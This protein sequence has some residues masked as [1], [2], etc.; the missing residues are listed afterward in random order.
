MAGMRALLLTAALGLVAGQVG[1]QCTNPTAPCDFTL[2]PTQLINSTDSETGYYFKFTVPANAQENYDIL[3]TQLY[4]NVQVYVTTNGALPS[5]DNFQA[6]TATSAIPTIVTLR[7]GDYFSTDGDTTVNMYVQAK[8]PSLAYIAASPD[9]GRI[10]LIMGVP[11]VD[12]AGAETI[13]VYEVT[14]P[15]GEDHGDIMFAVSFLA[16]DDPN[17]IV[18]DGTTTKSSHDEGNDHVSFH[19]GV[20]DHDVTYTIEVELSESE[21][22]FFLVHATSASKEYPLVIVPGYYIEDEVPLG[23]MRF[24]ALYVPPTHEELT[25]RVEP[26]HGNPQLFAEADDWFEWSMGDPFAQATWS[27][28]NF[29]GADEIDINPEDEHYIAEGGFYKVTIIGGVGWSDDEGTNTEYQIGAMTFGTAL[30]LKDGESMYDRIAEGHY[31][32]F[33]YYDTDPDKDLVIDVTAINGDPDIFVACTLDPTGDDSGTPSNAEGHFNVSSVSPGDD[34]LTIPSGS[35]CSRPGDPNMFYIGVYA[36]S[37]SLIRIATSHADPA[38]SVLLTAGQPQAGTVEAGELHTY[39]LEAKSPPQQIEITL[40]PLEGDPDLYVRM[41][42][43]MATVAEAM[44]EADYTA[45]AFDFAVDKVVIPQDEVCKNCNIYVAVHGFTEASYILAYSVNKS[46]LALVE[47]TPVRSSVGN[48]EVT[49]FSYL[50]LGPGDVHFTLTMLSGSA[51]LVATD[52]RTVSPRYPAESNATRVDDSALIGRVPSIVYSGYPE[53][54]MYT[55]GVQGASDSTFTLVA[56]TASGGDVVNTLLLGSPQDAVSSDWTTLYYVVT[57]PSGH[58]QLTISSR[59]RTGY[60]SVF[61]KSCDVE[62]MTCSKRGNYSFGLPGF[63]DN[64]FS[65]YS[66]DALIRIPYSNATS[67]NYFIAVKTDA[68]TDVTTQAT[69]E[70][71]QISLQIGEPYREYLEQDQTS[72]YRFEV[73]ADV[74]SDYILISVTDLSG[75]DPDVY[76]STAPIQFPNSTNFN[77]ANSRYGSESIVIHTNRNDSNA[78]V[79]CAYFVGVFAF[80]ETEYSIT[81]T[82]YQDTITTLQ[83]GQPQ[84]GHVARGQEAQY[85]YH[86]S[87]NTTASAEPPVRSVKLM[88]RTGDADLYCRLDGGVPDKDNYDYSSVHGGNWADTVDLYPDDE[89]YVEH[90][91]HATCDIRCAVI[92]WSD[93]DYRIFV[94]VGAPLLLQAGTPQYATVNGSNADNYYIPFA[95]GASAVEFVMTTFSGNANMLASCRLEDPSI[96]A[97][98][99]DSV[100]IDAQNLVL[101]RNSTPGC[102]YADTVYLAVQ[103]HCGRNMSME[104]TYQV[105]VTIN[106]DGRDEKNHLDIGVQQNGFAQPMAFKYYVVEV[107]DIEAPIKIIVSSTSGNTDLYLSYGWDNRPVVDANGNITNFTKSSANAFGRDAVDVSV[108]ELDACM[109]YS[110]A[111]DEEGGDGCYIVVGVIA[112]T[113]GADYVIVAHPMDDTI[114]TLQTGVPLS[115]DVPEG[116]YHYYHYI[117]ASPSVDLEISLSSTSGDADLYVA[118]PPLIRPNRTANDAHSVAFNTDVIVMQ[119]SELAEKCPESGSCDIYISVYGFRPNTQYSIVVSVNDGWNSPVSLLPGQAITS[120]VATNEYKYF[121]F[122]PMKQSAIIFTLMSGEDADSDLYIMASDAQPGKDHHDFESV[123]A[124]GADIVEVRPEDDNYCTDC[125][126]SIAVYGYVGGEFTISASEGLSELQDGVPI[127]GRVSDDEYAYYAFHNND[128]DADITISLTAVDG[129]PDLYVNKNRTSMPTSSS[130]IWQSFNVGDDAMTI[131]HTDDDYC[132][133]CDYIVGVKG[134]GNSTFSLVVSLSASSLISLP[135]GRPQ[136]GSVEDEAMRFYTVTS[137]TSGQTLRLTLSLISGAA[138]AYVRSMNAT[139]ITTEVPIDP[140]DSS[141]FAASTANTPGNEKVVTLSEGGGV[142]S[143]YVIGVKGEPTAEFTITASFEGEAITLRSGVPTRQFVRVQQTEFFIIDLPE[144]SGLEVSLTPIAGDPD[145]LISLENPHPSCSVDNRVENCN[146][147]TWKAAS[148]VDDVIIL[149][150]DDPCNMEKIGGRVT[151]ADDCPYTE[152]PVG[153]VYI[154]VFAYGLLDEHGNIVGNTDAEFTLTATVTGATKQLIPGQA[155]RVATSMTSICDNPNDSGTC[156]GATTERQVAYLKYRMSSE[157]YA[158]HVTSL[159]FRYFCEGDANCAFSAHAYV[160]SCASDSCE[161]RHHHP[162]EGNSEI[163]MPLDE[164]STSLFI[165]QS[166]NPDSECDNS[167]TGEGCVFYIAIIAAEGVTEP[168]TLDVTASSSTALVRLPC[169]PLT[170]GRDQQVGQRD[171]YYLSDVGSVNTTHMQYE[172]CSRPEQ[173]VGLEVCSGDVSYKICNGE[174]PGGVPGIHSWMYHVNAQKA[175]SK[176]TPD[177][178]EHCTAT[179]HGH[180]SMN[181]DFDEEDASAKTMTV[182]GSGT[183]RIVIDTLNRGASY[184]PQLTDIGEL[185]AEGVAGGVRLRW[186]HPLLQFPTSAA[187]V[188]TVSPQLHTYQLYIIPADI[189]RDTDAVFNTPCGLRYLWRSGARRNMGRIPLD[190]GLTEYTVQ[191]PEVKNYQFALLATCDGDCFKNGATE[192]DPSIEM[193][194]NCEPSGSCAAKEVVALSAETAPAPSGGGG[195]GGN[196]TEGSS[197]GA[198]MIALI[199]ILA[200]VGAVL[201]G[202][203]TAM[204]VVYIRQRR[205]GF[206]DVDFHMSDETD[207]IGRGLRDAMD[208]FADCFRGRPGGIGNN[209]GYASIHMTTFRVDAV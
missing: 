66:P 114:V 101:S 153:P 143:V 146:N 196:K 47:G 10:S 137:A 60:V 192:L 126:Y 205:M 68:N 132:S 131:L 120:Q 15:A 185:T 17:I 56:Y 57:V 83:D 105:V 36:Y 173:R 200:L 141:T 160:Q 184:S 188:V 71:T 3:L 91:G 4:G 110:P 55:I 80:R 133:D 193:L 39:V 149:P 207:R 182:E 109:Q 165:S 54:T 25:I 50:Q 159:S 202:V 162:S 40:T 85:T 121:V 51:Y 28:N 63:D 76:V 62:D 108:E 183:Y 87:Y 115:N 18:S 148:T 104:A 81:V 96:D 72:F 52:D 74:D 58:G 208:S 150:K 151:I 106:E 125:Q 178:Q 147:Y 75:G 145:L 21:E 116:T 203:G 169:V 170:T 19:H 93:T 138:D 136:Y 2:G 171:G 41:N 8:T 128:P 77:W 103:A 12:H 174:C 59:P 195:G 190:A 176:P 124:F 99:N 180:I 135:R 94:D 38:S 199:V 61:V 206:G 175:C 70:S 157:D 163:Q 48:G 119:S 82:T 161:P 16:L 164:Q 43:S 45:D 9:S 30:Q 117:I 144:S 44:I 127:S 7:P 122:H 166:S 167:A 142:D 209:D 23:Q 197:L 65:D 53:L 6:S 1:N 187:S 35:S 33:Q 152:M 201:L 204:G 98:H 46:A 78:C 13:P 95:E 111:E 11:Q 20:Q 29:Q 26:T 113:S 112:P 5:P 186:S 118:F 102:G 134:Y 194:T 123:H 130:Y 37:D 89:G 172:I 198:G 27:S 32:Y 107:L 31:H 84:S 129:D 92:G 79:N 22:A 158:E 73:G 67:M 168:I 179:G 156:D 100:V 42:A 86:L 88:V 90:C 181:I 139:G 155:M 14:V 24:A 177:G 140:N 69:K 34:T 154:G 97:Q 64:E 189:D 191:L 49:Y